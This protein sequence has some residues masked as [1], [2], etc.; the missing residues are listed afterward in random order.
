MGLDDHMLNFGPAEI[1]IMLLCLAVVA[2]L[3]LGVFLLVTRRKP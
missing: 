3:V 2:G 1:L